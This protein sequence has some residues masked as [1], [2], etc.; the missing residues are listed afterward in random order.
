M[1]KIN[2]AIA[3]C[4]NISDI[5][6]KNLTT[7][8]PHLQVYAISDLNEENT[9]IKSDKYKIEKTMTFEEIIA[10]PEV[11]IVLNL[12][13]PLFHYELSKHALEAGKHVYVEK[14]LSQKFEE[15]KKLVELA[16]EKGLLI[17]CAPDTFLG[18]GI[19]TCR[20]IIDEGL[21][22]NVFS[23]EAFMVCHGSENWHP[24]PEFF[25]K[26]GGG[27]MYDMGPYY[28]T[29]LINLV[30]SIKSVFGMNTSCAAVRRITS[31]PKYG[32]IIDVEVPTHVS[33][34]LRFSNGAV[35]NIVTSFDIWGSSL[36]RIEIHGT[37]GSLIV[38][39][40]N[41]FGGEI[42]LKQYFDEEFRRYPLLTEE[43]EDSRGIGLADMAKCI[44]ERRTNHRA[45]GKLALHVL[46]IME[47]IH[48][49]SDEHREITLETCCKRP[50]L[51]PLER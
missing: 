10:D 22:G 14:P 34:L 17:G 7:S 2:V 11:D 15:G 32:Q 26:A 42:L 40:P 39:D 16:E 36:P 43:S 48:T 49:S 12:T 50:D 3:G 45:S 37:R 25:Y 18:A 46:E 31:Q 29:A 13:P 33:A 9:K 23:A 51:M 1:K 5:Y 38:P 30:G 21:L 35:G 44:Q 47:K 27:P 8:H 19:Q 24:N 28:L 4:G 20:R 6:L 41:F